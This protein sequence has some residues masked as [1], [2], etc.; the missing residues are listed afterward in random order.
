MHRTDGRVVRSSGNSSVPSNQR[1]I[2][3]RAPA[4]NPA[5]DNS[6]A[7]MC[8]AE[9]PGKKM[10]SGVSSKP[11]TAL[12]T[13][14]PNVSWVCVTPFGL[15][16]LPDVKKMNTGVSGVGAGRSGTSESLVK[17]SSRLGFGESPLSSKCI[18]PRGNLPASLL[19]ARSASRST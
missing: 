9:H 2:S 17:N 14:H 15:P 7:P 12:A 18:R 6:E 11:A 5:S 10:S 16:V 19:L 8:D 1:A 4:A 13:I 3:T